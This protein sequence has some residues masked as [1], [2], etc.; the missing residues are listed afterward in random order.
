MRRALRL[1]Q[2]ADVVRKRRAARYRRRQ[3]QLGRRAAGGVF[4]GNLP[5]ACRREP[6]TWGCAVVIRV[7]DR[8]VEPSVWSSVRRMFMAVTV[9]LH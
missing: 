5:S 4:T 1:R 8:G 3:I 7:T 2:S 9:S 6:V